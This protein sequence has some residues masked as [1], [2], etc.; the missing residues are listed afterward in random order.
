MSA[1]KWTSFTGHCGH[2]HV[3][4]NLHGDPGAFP[5]VAILTAAKGG[6]TRPRRTTW[7]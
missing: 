6:T 7:P 3:P 1:A 5:M 4:E 2:Q